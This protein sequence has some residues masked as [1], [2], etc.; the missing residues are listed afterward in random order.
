MWNIFSGG[1]LPA[2]D[3]QCRR[4]MSAENVALYVWQIL[5]NVIMTVGSSGMWNRNS[6]EENLTFW[7][8]HRAAARRLFS[9]ACAGWNGRKREKCRESMLFPCSFRRTDSAKKRCESVVLHTDLLPV[10]LLA[11][12]QYHPYIRH[13]KLQDERYPLH[14]D[15]QPLFVDFPSM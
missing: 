11:N 7:I 10:M 8:H 3:R 2:R 9:G 12:R 15:Q 13:L 14:S 4:K 5:E 6:T 1:S